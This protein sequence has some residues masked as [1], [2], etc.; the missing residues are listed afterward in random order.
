MELEG[1]VVAVTGASSG[2]GAATAKAVADEG[3]HAVL[4]ARTREALDEVAADVADAGGEASVV[5]V[6]LADPVA[7]EDAAD[8]IRAEV[9][10]PD[11]LVNNA[12]IGRWLAIDETTP[13]QAE[14]YV[15]VPY[16]GAFYL[17]R[18]FVDDM[19]VRDSGHVV[20]V[21]SPA[22]YTPP[23]GAT[24]YNAARWAMRGFTQSLRGDFRG[25]GIGVTLVVPGIVDSPY[26]EHNPG[27]AE[28]L[29]GIGAL[30]RTVSPER[31][32]SAIARGIERERR[33]VVTPPE[34][35]LLMVFHRLLPRLVQWPVDRTGWSR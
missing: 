8:T 34:V 3:A 30:F 6:D 16:L 23:P 35:R 29:P 2:I 5:T 18:E 25:T 12:G 9:G 17:T 4:L 26:F 27:T 21:T 15:A 31:V 1:A 14:R 28:R 10:T 7:V 19:L 20:N 32:A 24:A 22:A 33:T 13:E 11:V